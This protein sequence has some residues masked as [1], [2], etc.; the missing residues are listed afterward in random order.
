MSSSSKHPWE[1]TG[2]RHDEKRQR[3]DAMVEDVNAMLPQEEQ[4]QCKE[5]VGGKKADREQRARKVVAGDTVTEAHMVDNKD[6]AAEADEQAKGCSGKG[7]AGKKKKKETKVPEAKGPVNQTWV[8]GARTCWKCK[9]GHLWCGTGEG[10]DISMHH[11]LGKMTAKLFDL[12]IANA[13]TAIAIKCIKGKIDDLTAMMKVVMEAIREVEAVEAQK[14]QVELEWVQSLGSARLASEEGLSEKVE[15]KMANTLSTS[16]LD[17]KGG[18]ETD[19]EEYVN[20][21]KGK[22]RT[23]VEELD[24]EEDGEDE[25]TDDEGSEE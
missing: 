25:R 17:E 3:E 10:I 9:H 13:R 24:A 6:E 12:S 7:V 21:E 5:C 4:S 15:V 14:R 23:F 22:G 8:K 18:V 19:E 2:S 20:K 1:S 16:D 11:T